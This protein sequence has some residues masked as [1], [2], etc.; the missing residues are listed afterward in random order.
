MVRGTP[1][2]RYLQ[3]VTKVLVRFCNIS[4]GTPLQKILPEIAILVAH[5]HF[6]PCFYSSMA[7]KSKEDALRN[8]LEKERVRKRVLELAQSGELSLK[9]IADHED[10]QKAGP[11]PYSG[12]PSA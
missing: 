12:M 9:Q 3:F 4:F 10:V 2:S 11:F 7:P 1:T 8:K 5:A 6:L